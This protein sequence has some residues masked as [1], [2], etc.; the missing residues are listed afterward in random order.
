M[1]GRQGGGW[2]LPP[3]A[4]VQPH[5]LPGKLSILNDRTKEVRTAESP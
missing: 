4:S 5:L 3:L 2:A 1:A